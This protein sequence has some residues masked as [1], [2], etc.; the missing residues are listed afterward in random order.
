MSTT[1]TAGQ[2]ALIENELMAREHALEAEW[3]TLAEQAGASGDS[4]TALASQLLNDDPEAAREHP[5]DRAVLLARAD[6][7]RQE[8]AAIG[9]ALIALR[10]GR[11]G[12]CSDCGEPIAFDRLKAQPMA[13]R[14]LRCQTAFEAT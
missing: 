5:D 8:Q 14:C 4:R 2:R 7:L 9:N 13:P 10:E 11:L 3:R 6:Q 12:E 1:L